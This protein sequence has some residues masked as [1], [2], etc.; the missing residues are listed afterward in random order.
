MNRIS[1]LLHL[2]ADLASAGSK[3][4][5]RL[6]GTVSRFA[7]AEEAAPHDPGRILPGAPPS[8]VGE[9]ESPDV[10]GFADT[11]FAFN[12]NG[13]VELSGT[14]YALSGHELPGLVPW[15]EGML[16]VPIN[17]KEVHE[18]QYPPHIPEPIRHEGFLAAI[19]GVL[20]PDQ[21]SDD[22]AVRL[23]H[24]HGHTQEEMYALKYGALERVPDLVLHP[25]EE[26]HVQAL[27]QLALV[28]D[29]C[30]IPYGGGTN[31][32]QALKCA[33]EERRMIVSVDMSR[34]NRI[35]WID[36]H[37]SHG[38][39]PGWRRR[40]PHRS[41][42]SKST[43]SRWVTSPTASSS[44]RMGGWIATHASGMKKNRY[45][46]IEDIV[47]DVTVSSRPEACSSAA[48]WASARDVGGSATPLAPSSAPRVASASS[49]RRW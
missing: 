46:N 16:Q 14:R 24:G 11:R 26:A 23:R 28:H 12:R 30:L 8:A 48:T 15:M 35:L 22:P 18:S 1:R 44:P 45:G 43:A 5:E 34:M 29:V 13:N 33:A 49:R 32:T 42:S 6:A 17:R 3:G 47:L 38:V 25:T 39:H 37:E 20:A 41:S 7:D 19:A 21:M 10:W 2:S 9:E 40:P 27:T 31:V 4:L 36:P